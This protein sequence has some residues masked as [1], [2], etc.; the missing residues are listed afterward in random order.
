MVIAALPLRLVNAR[1]CEYQ[2]SQQ[3]EYRDRG[4]DAQGIFA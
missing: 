4:E 2:K 3:R 1:W